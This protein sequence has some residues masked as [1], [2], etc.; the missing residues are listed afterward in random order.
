MD[1]ELQTDCSLATD[2]AVLGGC[3]M[4]RAPGGRC[5]CTHQ[6]ATL[7]VWN[8]VMVAILNVWVTSKIWLRHSMRIYS[9]NNRAKYYDHS[10]PIWNAG[11]FGFIKRVAPTTTTTTTRWVAIW[12]QFLAH[13]QIPINTINSRHK[14]CEIPY[15]TD[16]I[17]QENYQYV[18]YSDYSTV[19][20][21][22]PC[23]VHGIKTRKVGLVLFIQC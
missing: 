23:M 12:D 15:S 17:L 1:Q 4:L 21:S 16:V 11:A 22:C 7:C 9:R 5:V 13:K 18:M 20:P 3:S 14:Q 6:M 10:D 19:S 2:A 8:D